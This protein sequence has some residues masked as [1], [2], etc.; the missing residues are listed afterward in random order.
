M[1]SVVS[2]DDDVDAVARVEFHP[3]VHLFSNWRAK[4]L[5]TRTKKTRV[6]FM[7]DTGTCQTDEGIA[8]GW[9]CMAIVENTKRVKRSKK[10]P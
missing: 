8:I 10:K 5:V 1:V 2:S 6:P 9:S 3:D 7:I 4:L